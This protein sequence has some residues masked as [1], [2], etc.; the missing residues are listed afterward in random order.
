M[1]CTP[2]SKL[3]IKYDTSL[4]Y[5]IYTVLCAVKFRIMFVI[6]ILCII[7]PIMTGFYS[8]IDWDKLDEK[9]FK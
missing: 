3:K 5:N 6:I 4:A 9:V 1:C 7:L 8:I 2:N